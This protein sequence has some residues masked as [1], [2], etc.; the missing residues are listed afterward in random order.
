MVV[1]VALVGN[2]NV[3]KTSI[4]NRLVGARQYV[5]NWPGVTVSKIEGA[6]EWKGNTLHFIDLPGTYSL[7]SKSIDEKITRDFLF[8]SPPN[9]TLLIADS[10]NPE[11]SFYLLIETLEITK[12]VILVMNSYDEVKRQKT[13][14]DKYELQKHF[15][16]PVVFT[17]AK[18]G[19][20]ISELKDMIVDIAKGKKIKNV[21]FD[22]KEYE[23]I[24]VDIEN[25]IPDD[26]FKNKRYA[27]LK[28]LEGDEYFVNKLE[29]IVKIDKAIKENALN[30]IPKIRYEYVKYV[31]KEAYSG[32][33]IEYIK[34]MNDKIDHVLTHKI[35]GIPILVAIMYII[36][37]FTF[38]VVQPLADILDYSFSQLADYVKSFGDGLFTSLIADGLIGGVG[39]VLV[40]VPNI[41]ALF[42]ALGILEE[43]GY[44][45]RAA[46]VLDRIM[47]KMKLSGRSF[48]SLLLGFGCNVPSIMTARGLP[49]EKERLGTIL[50]APFISCSARFP[51]YM[52]IISIF[53]PR[54]K[55]EVLFS[56]YAISILITAF[57]A[58]F[59][60]KVFFKGE[61]VPLVMELPRYRVPTIRNIAIYMWNKGSHFLKK[62]GTIILIT[63]ILVWGLTYFP[64]KGDVETSYA[65]YIGKTL[66]YILKPLGFDWK[67]GTALFF[68]GVAKEVIVSTMSMLYGF[69]EGD[70]ISAKL[71]LSESL[72][73]VNAYAFLIFVMLYIPCFA[74]IATI[75]SETGSWKWVIFT[76]IYSFLIAYI[77]SFIFLNLGKLIIG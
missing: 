35:F 6:T 41:F 9:V 62:A 24:I 59:V 47:Y 75:K 71:A 36:F 42:I 20:G 54:Y 45:P 73:S 58:F 2:P 31:L 72:N 25:Q 21:I 33:N 51:V 16:V 39:G 14:I 37:K 27:A 13:K 40:F 3:G 28:Y 76:V 18:T 53:F 7:S 74:T 30:H 48:M 57:T 29:N 44:L 11:Q 55:A 52:M 4:F 1:T 77:L 8:F 17:S 43:T 49:D 63:S 61:S 15:G 23:K 66:E 56:I 67:I 46:F 50:S 12:S 70:L 68:G 60:N 64:N 19:E 69:T 22:Y 10:L 38:D 34:T 32:N 65:S 26:L 5:A